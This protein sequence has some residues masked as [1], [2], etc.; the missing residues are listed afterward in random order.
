M[1][2]G[3]EIMPNEPA[4]LIAAWA[5]KKEDVSAADMAL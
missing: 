4:P 3:A 1:M 5:T 2:R